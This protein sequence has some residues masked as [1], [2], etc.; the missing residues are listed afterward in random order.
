PD[1]VSEATRA[2]SLDPAGHE[3]RDPKHVER[4]ADR[5][6]EPELERSPP[7]VG[8]EQEVEEHLGEA[9][10][11]SPRIGGQ[12]ALSPPFE[13]GRRDSGMER[14]VLGTHLAL[15][16][17]QKDAE[18]DR[19][20]IERVRK[21]HGPMIAR[22]RGSIPSRRVVFGTDAQSRDRSGSANAVASD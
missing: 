13:V 18:Q 14:R 22:L 15:S 11:R 7:Q 6:L 10:P 21:N 12:S 9:R 16:E 4:D 3:R 2:A 1:L 17:E 19:D 8:Q 20:D 5:L